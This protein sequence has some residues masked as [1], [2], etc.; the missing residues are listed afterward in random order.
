MFDLQGLYEYG[1]T[2]TSTVTYVLDSQIQAWLKETEATVSASRRKQLLSRIQKR[3]N[4]EVYWSPLWAQKL[5]IGV[6]NRVNAEVSSD[7]T[8]RLYLFSWKK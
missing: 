1:L 4:D 7:D 8:L 5:S 6:S 3:I 2:D